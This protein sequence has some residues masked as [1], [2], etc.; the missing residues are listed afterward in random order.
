MISF[1]AVIVREGLTQDFCGRLKPISDKWIPEALAVSGFTRED[2]FGFDD[3]KHVM[4]TFAHW[5]KENAQGRALF[6]SDTTVSIGSS[7]RPKTG[8]RLGS[9]GRHYWLSNP[10]QLRERI[11]TG[12]LTCVVLLYSWPAR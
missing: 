9:A 10:P 11:R 8:L 12:R 5:I 3:P 4:E 7:S 6:A 1:G 2:T